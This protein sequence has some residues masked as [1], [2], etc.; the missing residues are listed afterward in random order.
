MKDNL[1]GLIINHIAIG[2]CLFAV[3]IAPDATEKI[4]PTVCI[5]VNAFYIWLKTKKEENL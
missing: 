3:Y 2:L 4:A 1:L 5:A